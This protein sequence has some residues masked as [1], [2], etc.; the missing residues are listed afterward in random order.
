MIIENQI[1]SLKVKDVSEKI[2]ENYEEINQ[3]IFK[4]VANYGN[5]IMDRCSRC[6]SIGCNG[7]RYLEVN[8]NV[9]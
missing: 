5:S 9:F 2:H 3:K 4:C 8:K 6:K 7:C 1:T